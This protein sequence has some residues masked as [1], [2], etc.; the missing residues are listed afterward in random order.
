MGE[1]KKSPPAHMFRNMQF[2]K[3]NMP[4]RDAWRAG[5]VYTYTKKKKEETSTKSLNSGE[6]VMV[7]INI[8]F[9]ALM[10]FLCFGSSKPSQ[11]YL[12]C[13]FLPN[14]CVSAFFLNVANSFTS[15]VFPH[16]I[17][18]LLGKLFF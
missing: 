11:E 3:S 17:K 5:S 18:L 12:V 7:A 2:E 8:F 4:L 15:T 13:K 14:V 16:F 10:S 6:R 9:S 1:K